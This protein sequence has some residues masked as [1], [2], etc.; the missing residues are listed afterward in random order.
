MASKV[1]KKIKCQSKFLY[2][3]SRYLTRVSR[4]QVLNSCVYRESLYL[5]PACKVTPMIVN[6]S[7]SFLF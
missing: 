4:K 1:L 3:E 7:S 6:V 5:T 2:Q